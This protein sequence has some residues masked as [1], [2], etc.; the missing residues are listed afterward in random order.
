MNHKMI[1]IIAFI[2]S[3]L[4]TTQQNVTK[5]TTSSFAM[6]TNVCG[7]SEFGKNF[8]ETAAVVKAKVLVVRE[9]NDQKK[10]ILG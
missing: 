4:I 8:V 2:A 7:A 10:P 5:L 6:C 3:L 1:S 9:K